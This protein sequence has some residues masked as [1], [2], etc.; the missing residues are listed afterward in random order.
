MIGL[1]KTG[2]K[3]QTFFPTQ[4]LINMLDQFG[5]KVDPNAKVE[6]IAA[7][8]VTADL[9]AFE[10]TGSQIDVTV[11]SVGDAAS[12]QGGILLRTPLNGVDGQTYALAQGSLVLGGFSAGGGGNGTTVNH[13]TVGRIPG[14]GVVEKTVTVGLPQTVETL[15][16]VLDQMDFTNVGRV[17]AAVNTSFGG[18][19]ASA[20]DGRSVRLTLPLSYQKK[21]VDF[22]ATLE[23][24]MV[25]TDTKAR[26]VVNE[27][28]GTV[29]I[30]ADVT[31]SPVSIAHGNLNISVETQ[32]Q[33]SQPQPFSQG[34]TTAVPEVKVPPISLLNLPAEPWRLEF[35]FATRRF[36][37]THSLSTRWHSTWRARSTR[38]IPR[39]TISTEKPGPIYFPRS[40]QL[41][42]RP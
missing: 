42:T 14:G 28:T 33:V 8:I 23:N 26:V 38:C 30:G 12:L 2:D 22:I 6:N 25:Q 17:V 35:R 21:P 15:D 37:R 9:P 40:L 29:V 20:M 11:S 36:Q 1:N 41:P 39:H 24:V 34:Q 18:P 27:R 16:L 31:L 7:V 19:I 3:K 4:T 10:R 13:P 5:M 32:T